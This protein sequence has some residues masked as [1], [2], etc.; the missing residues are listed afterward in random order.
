MGDAQ[1]RTTLYHYTLY[2][3]FINTKMC[4]IIAFAISVDVQNLARIC[5]LRAAL[6]ICKYNDFV[7]F[8]LPYLAFLLGFLADRIATQYDRL[9]ASYCRLPLSICLSVCPSVTLCIV[10]L[11][12]GVD[13]QKLYRRVPSMQVSTYSLLL[14]IVYQQNTPKNELA[15]IRQVDTAGACDVNKVNVTLALLYRCSHSVKSAVR[16]CSFTVRRTQYDRPS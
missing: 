9:L 7:T 14:Y 15:T 6:Q 2:H 13:G 8:T 16:F 3:Y 10:A 12:V 4:A 1:I 5:S 11:R